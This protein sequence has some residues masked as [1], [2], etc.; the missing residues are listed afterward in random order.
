MKP[1]EEV[2]ACVIDYGTFASIAEVLARDM[3]RVYYHTPFAQE[4]Q[5]VRECIQGAGLD[6]VERLDYIFDPAV[7]DSIDLW[8][9]PDIGYGDLQRLLRRDGKAVW[10]HFLANEIEVYR[11][12]FLDTLKEAKLPMVH[13]EVITGMDELNRYLKRTENKWVK[14]N[15]FRNQ[16]DTWH[17][18]TYMESRATLDSLAVIFGGA[19]NEIVFVVQDDIPTDDGGE[20]GYDGWCIDGQYPVRSFQGYEKKNELYLGSLLDYTDLPEEIRTVN[21]ALSPIL[22]RYGYRNWWSTEIRISKGVPYFIDATPRMAGQTG[23]HQLESCRNFADVVWQ[24]A[25]GVLIE[26]DFTASYA[27]EAT[28]HYHGNTKDV[29]IT[30]EWKSLEIPESVL[31][32]IKLYHYCKIDGAYHF[33]SRNTDEVGVVLGLGDSIMEACRHLGKNLSEL[34]DLPVSTDV[35]GFAELIKAIKAADARGMSFG[36]APIPRPETIYKLKGLGG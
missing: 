28:L 11:T 14:V 24:G 34:K 36:A 5:D 19:R 17:H 6:K 2:T 4:Y 8:V 9:F 7:Y 10:G 31:Q 1:V 15:R 35:S 30:D 21:D 32:W 16:M 12:L 13:N 26:P 20:A 18:K 23:E 33:P 22:R 25:N 3:R 27:A 29:T